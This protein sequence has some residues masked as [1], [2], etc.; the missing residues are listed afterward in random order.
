MASQFVPSRFTLYRDSSGNVS[1]QSIKRSG[2][3]Y[4]IT[5][6]NAQG[7]PQPPG[8]RPFTCT[9][10]SGSANE[11]SFSFNFSLLT[12]TKDRDDWTNAFKAG[13]RTVFVSM[14]IGSNA[15][16]GT[17][18]LTIDLR[19]ATVSAALTQAKSAVVLVAKE[20]VVLF[21]SLLTVAHFVV[22]S[23][24]GLFRKKQEPEAILASEAAS[25]HLE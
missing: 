22:L 1:T 10:P 25:K 24:A 21:R 2:S 17:E 18:W 12:T 11:A 8:G 7:S 23:F 14:S 16:G 19:E 5:A 3:T 15:A 4:Q 20:S 6:A 9:T 13:N